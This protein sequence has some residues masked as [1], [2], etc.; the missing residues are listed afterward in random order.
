MNRVT[1]VT[2]HGSIAQPPMRKDRTQNQKVLI[3]KIVVAK[4]TLTK[5][6]ADVDL[7]KSVVS[8]S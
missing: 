4:I 7:S 6:S 3:E 8:L 5:M 2:S 1:D